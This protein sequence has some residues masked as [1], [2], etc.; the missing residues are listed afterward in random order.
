MKRIIVTT[1][2]LL[3]IAFGVYADGIGG[4]GIG[5]GGIGDDGIGGSGF[6]A[7]GCDTGYTRLKG[8]DGNAISDS[9]GGLICCPN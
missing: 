5:D 7:S 2:C 9:T 8:S 3:F 6:E 4:G 1:L